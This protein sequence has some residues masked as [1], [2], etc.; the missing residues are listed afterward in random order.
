MLTFV[1]VRSVQYACLCAWMCTSIR[2]C[3]RV[4]TGVCAS[5]CSLLKH[6]KICMHMLRMLFFSFFAVFFLHPNVRGKK[7]RWSTVT[8]RSEIKETRSWTDSDRDFKVV[9]ELL[10]SFIFLFLY[11]AGKSSRRR[12]FLPCVVSLEQSNV[13][14]CHAEMLVTCQRERERREK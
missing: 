12:L 14:F 7:R 9:C 8:Q 4:C 11:P 13:I 2:V 6:T 3:E 10:G 5:I 1:C